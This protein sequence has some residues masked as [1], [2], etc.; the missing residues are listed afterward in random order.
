MSVGWRQSLCDTWEREFLFRLVCPSSELQC[1]C[2]HVCVC[3]LSS[4]MILL[5]WCV[6]TSNCIIYFPL[7]FHSFD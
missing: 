5:S 4:I 3:V 7:H 1:V 6:Y 2:V